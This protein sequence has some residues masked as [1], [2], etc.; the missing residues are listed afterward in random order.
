MIYQTS[1]R[2]LMETPFWGTSLQGQMKALET[3]MHLYTDAAVILLTVVA[4]LLVYLCVSELRQSGS[5]GAAPRKRPEARQADAA[6]LGNQS[7]D[8]SPA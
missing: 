1:Y 5:A 2:P 4:G 3:L 6:T 8:S 7:Y